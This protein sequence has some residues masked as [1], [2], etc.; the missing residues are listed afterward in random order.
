MKDDVSAIPKNGCNVLSSDVRIYNFNGNAR[1]EYIN[2]GG[3]WYHNSTQTS[4]YYYDISGYTCVD[5][6]DLNSNAVFE[7]ILYWCSFGL[8]L[9]AVGLFFYVLK[10]AFYAIK[11]D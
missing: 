3:K 10:R 4:N 2:I 9:V 5:V 8:F 6:S 7:P 1:R 11:V